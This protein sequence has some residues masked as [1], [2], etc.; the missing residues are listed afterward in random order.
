MKHTL[1]VVLIMYSN[2]V[3]A[4]NDEVLLFMSTEFN[5]TLPQ[6]KDKYTTLEKTA[7]ASGVF[8]YIFNH[9]QKKA[10]LPMMN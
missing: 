10:I 8:M 6:Q 3:F 9:A 7:Y 5:K 1:L 4:Y 2:S